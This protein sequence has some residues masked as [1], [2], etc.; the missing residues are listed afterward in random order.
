MTGEYGPA[1]QRHGA[2]LQ[3]QREPEGSSLSLTLQ[4]V[5]SVATGACLRRRRRQGDPED[6][7]F[8]TFGWFIDPEGNKVELWQPK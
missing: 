3:N 8:G 2:A 4:V 7:E 1:Q 6:S 5:A